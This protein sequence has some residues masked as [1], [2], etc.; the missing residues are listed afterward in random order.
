MV[1]IQSKH[2]GV[3]HLLC[4]MHFMER[5]ISLAKVLKPDF[6]KAVEMAVGVRVFIVK[7]LPTCHLFFALP[8]IVMPIPDPD[9]EPNS[10]IWSTF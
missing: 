9:P 8:L 4:Q 2:Q 1:I 6:S 10:H 7:M 3:R 5:I